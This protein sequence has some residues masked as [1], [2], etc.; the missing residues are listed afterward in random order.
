MEEAARSLGLE[1]Q[2][3]TIRGPDDF[4]SAFETAARDRAGAV[5]MGAGTWSA[6]SDVTRVVDLAARH[7]LPTIY[8]NSEFIPAGGLMAYGV[9]LP[10]QFRRAASY[11]DKILKGAKPGDLP[12][13]QPTRFDFAIN[14]KT[15]QA[16]GLTIPSHVL[17]Q[18]TEVIQ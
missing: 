17:A 11:V 13:E 3:L 14:L 16:L 7:R 12:I 1:L 5:L 9:H 10:D 6:S 4:E 8:Q 2:P 15:A 18:A